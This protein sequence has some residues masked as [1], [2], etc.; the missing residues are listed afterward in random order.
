MRSEKN[1]LDVF[2]IRMKIGRMA[3]ALVLGAVCACAMGSVAYAAD[4]GLTASQVD[5]GAPIVKTQAVDYSISWYTGNPDAQEFTIRTRAELRGFAK[6]V[7]GTVDKGVA[8]KPAGAVTFEGKTV[9]LDGQLSL[10][11]YPIEPIGTEEHP[12]QG[13][14]DGGWA[15]SLSTMGTMSSGGSWQGISAA[16]AVIQAQAESSLLSNYTLSAQGE[17]EDVCYQGLFGYAGDKATIKNLL[18]QGGSIEVSNSFDGKHIT[19]VGAIAGH[20]GGSIE[21]CKSTADV[22]VTNDGAVPTDRND[23]PYGMCTVLYVGG[24]VGSLG[25]DMRN[26]V[27]GNASGI[28]EDAQLIVSSTASTTMNVPYI[29]SYVGG[30][31]GLQ[32]NEQRGDLA[33]TTEHCKNY[34][35]VLF[36]LTGAAEPDR[37]GNVTYARSAVAGG[38]AGY[39]IASFAD[40]ANAATINTGMLGSDGNPLPWRGAL[41]TGGIVG[42]LRAPIFRN[43]NYE[44]IEMGSDPTD[45]GYDVW[46]ES[47]GAEQPP[48]LTVKRCQNT[49]Y[50][51]GL[52]AVGGIVGADGAFTKV[53]GCANS[54]MVDATRST[55]PCPAGI[56][57]V[58]NGDV[59][60]CSNTGR[61][62]TTTGAGYYAAG[63]VSILTTYNISGLDAALLLDAA[64]VY[65]CYVTSPIVSTSAGGF[66]SAV[67]VAESD[68]YLHDNCYLSNLTPDKAIPKDW[69]DALDCISSEDASIAEGDVAQVQ[70]MLDRVNVLDGKAFAISGGKLVGGSV[71]ELKQCCTRSQ[72][73]SPAEDRGTNVRNLEVTVEELKGSFGI[74]H[75]NRGVGLSGDWS[76]EA[77]YFYKSNSGGFPVLNWQGGS[78]A[79]TVD[80]ST[81]SG[82]SVSA[83]SMPEYSAVA[84]PVP[85]LEVT[86]NGAKLYQNA[87]F[88]V[89]VDPDAR[90]VGESYQA[91]IVGMNDYEGTLADAA[92]YTVAKCDVGNCK[93]TAVS[94]V[95]NWERQAPA[96]VM[97]IDDA[98]NVME[99]DAD[100][101]GTS[102]FVWS[103]PAM[104]QDA[105]D[106]VVSGAKKYKD[107]KYYDY[108]HFHSEGYLYDIV[109]KAKESSKHYVGQTQQAAFHITPGSLYHGAAGSAI[110]GQNP[111]ANYDKVVHGKQEWDF[112]DALVTKGLVKIKYTGKAIEPTI[113]NPTYLG[114]TLR[115]GTGQK[116]WNAPLDYD[117]RY[118]YGNP[119]PDPNNVKNFDCVNVTGSDE[120][121][122]ASVTMRFTQG[123]DFYNS[124]T[125]FFEIVPASIKTDVKVSGI[126][127]SYTYTGA[128][129]KSTAKLTYNGMTLKEGSDYTVT[130]K[131]NTKVG[132]ASVTFTGKGNYSGSVTKQFSIVKAKNGL[133][134]KGLSPKLSVKKLAKKSLAVKGFKITKATGK[135]TVALVKSAKTKKFKVDATG[136]ITVPKGTKKGAYTVKV[137]V[138]AAGDANHA[139]A[140]KVVKTQVNVK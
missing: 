45:P 51:V 125:V 133:T 41:N 140:A 110:E 119:N 2:P 73:V 27:H 69:Q 29:A 90:E 48:L 111:T 87:D 137:R 104:P 30:L 5:E 100:E 91:T 43:P 129:I 12:F 16:A 121:K 78:Q 40:C 98:G 102:D 72:I 18:L 105:S 3:A 139:S 66:K 77:F 92:A 65:G 32:G 83:A 53:I 82:L 128:K 64:E 19:D 127:A 47:N 131:N 25:G 86:L 56:V 116:Y 11:N 34:G 39:S 109:V 58:A 38:I 1:I 70:E 35:P 50:V 120:A 46:T 15:D 113:K 95:F 20:L 136:K 80:I 75:L 112:V 107:G 74:A 76:D 59:A 44:M 114:R 9:A 6:L 85:W 123:G 49:G 54:G 24:L 96:K 89:V 126:K 10:N 63:I 135:V 94:R 33:Q 108:T 13:T 97:L 42:A 23:T 134:V 106:D 60:Y 17:G 21:N 130:F 81:A 93:V 99:A 68:G 132:K 103:L 88:R 26:C 67:I 8:G 117:F 4:T 115:D 84:A 71:G 79:A 22:K 55:K 36:E 7:N 101:S 52:A 37:F 61:V 122:L 14:F 138:N 62:R 57:G 28:D 118:V 124:T 31:V